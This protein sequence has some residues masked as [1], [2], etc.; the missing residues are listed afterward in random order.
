MW[1]LSPASFQSGQ[2]QAILTYEGLPVLIFPTPSGHVVRGPVPRD[3]PR[4][5]VT[6]VRDRLIPN[7]SRSGDL[8]LQR[9]DK[10]PVPRDANCLKQEQDVQDYLLRRE[11]FF[12][13]AASSGPLGPAC[14]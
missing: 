2:D 8:A 10:L 6:V 13:M 7:G 11:H 5:P 9:Q 12:A 14:L 3:R 1:G 4:T